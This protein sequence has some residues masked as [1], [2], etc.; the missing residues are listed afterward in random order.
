M[1]SGTRISVDWPPAPLSESGWRRRIEELAVRAE[2]LVGRPCSLQQT[3]ELCM[4]LVGLVWPALGEASTVAATCRASLVMGRPGAGGLTITSKRP[5]APLQQRKARGV[6][7]SC[8]CH[9]TGPCSAPGAGLPSEAQLKPSQL[10]QGRR[11]PRRGEAAALSVGD[12]TTKCDPK[13]ARL[14]HNVLPYK[15]APL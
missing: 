2:S 5:A 12:T 3:A 4:E 6:G 15:T 13:S 11:H 8:D 10:P 7:L 9:R 14:P 1:S